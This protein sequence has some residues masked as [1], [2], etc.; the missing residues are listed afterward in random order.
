MTEEGRG[1]ESRGAGGENAS[2]FLVPGSSRRRPF[3]K[4]L[5]S[6]RVK[7][8][9]PLNR[10]SPAELRNE[11]SNLLAPPALFPSPT[12][13]KRFLETLFLFVLWSPGF[14]WNIYWLRIGPSIAL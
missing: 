6:V 5:P 10:H 12:L 1:E 11:K 9:Q 4:A 2:R 8:A 13:F 3:C 14:L 7:E